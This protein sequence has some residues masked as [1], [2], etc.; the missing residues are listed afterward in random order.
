MMLT[1][2]S[3]PARDVLL[4]KGNKGVQPRL[5]AFSQLCQP[6]DLPVGFAETFFR[7]LGVFLGNTRQR[8][9]GIGKRPYS[10]IR[11]AGVF[12]HRF[13]ACCIATV[14]WYCLHIADE[15]R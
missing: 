8:K 9:Q 4:D 15:T 10:F 1:L 13:I 5:G 11:L 14:A 2:A 6:G 3:V 7:L 12:L